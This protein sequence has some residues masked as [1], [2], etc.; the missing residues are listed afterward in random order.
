MIHYATFPMAFYT[1]RQRLLRVSLRIVVSLV[2]IFLLAW[3]GLAWYVHSHKDQIRVQLNEELEDRLN[4]E[5]KMGS[6]Y[7]SMFHS[8]PNISLAVSNV[9][10]KDSLWDEHKHD[11]VQAKELYVRLNPWA[12]LRNRVELKKVTISHGTIFLYTDSTGY[13]NSYLLAKK[14][15]NK[16][17][18]KTEIELF[19][20]EDMHLWY[21]NKMKQKLFHLYFPWLEGNTN[22]SREKVDFRITA[23]AHVHEFN[24][25]VTRGSYLKNQDLKLDFSMSYLLKD[26]HLKIPEQDLQIGNTTI[27][28]G[29]NF[30]FGQNP[31]QF[32]IAL[33]GRDVAY[34][35]ALAWVS[36]NIQRV[37]KAYDFAKPVSMNIS[38]SGRMKYRSIPLIRILYTI[39]DNTFITPLGEIEHLSYTGEYFNEAVIG[40]GHGDNNSRLGLCN[41]HRCYAIW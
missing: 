18:R 30:Y 13:A 41:W 23:A 35:T 25:N 19:G 27:Q 6:M 36:P 24:F 16:R 15:N 39:D 20:M 2:L 31:P 8:F 28:F 3:L 12:L 1:N 22:R 17:D 10:L 33:K 38:V 21:V 5:A 26:K 14:K 32:D 34:K 37:M 7:I 9:S 4:G 29:G 40:S 11:L